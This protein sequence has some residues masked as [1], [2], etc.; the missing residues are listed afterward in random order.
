[1]LKN[2]LFVVLCLSIFGWIGYQVVATNN[3]DNGIIILEDYAHGVI[4]CGEGMTI[5]HGHYKDVE[6]KRLIDL[7]DKTCPK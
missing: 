5:N 2:I 3:K 7:A 1:M 6:V 4:L